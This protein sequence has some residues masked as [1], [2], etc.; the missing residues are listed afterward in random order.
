MSEPLAASY[1]KIDVDR[2]ADYVVVRLRGRLIAGVG[3]FLYA[4]V[5]PLISGTGRIV[6]DLADVTQLDSMGLATLVRLYVSAKSEGC[7]LELANVGKQ[8]RQILSVTRLLSVFTIV[9]ESGL[10]MP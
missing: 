2:T 1:L 5:R 10:R 9:G 3:S 8:I 4:E 6:V 7:S